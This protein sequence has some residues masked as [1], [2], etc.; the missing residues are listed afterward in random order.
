MWKAY[1]AI[2]IS[3]LCSQLCI[4]FR[5]GA[6]K[7]FAYMDHDYVFN[8][9]SAL[10]TSLPLNCVTPVFQWDSL[11]HGKDALINVPQPLQPAPPNSSSHSHDNR[12]PKD[13]PWEFANQSEEPSN[14]GLR[15]AGIPYAT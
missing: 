9:T 13:E 15:R 1:D 10:F 6:S 2:V 7:W 4:L 11:I 12:G 3:S 14:V 5:I 8:E